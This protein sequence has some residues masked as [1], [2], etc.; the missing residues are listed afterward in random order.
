MDNN[1]PEDLKFDQ[2][3]SYSAVL[4]ALAEKKRDKHLLMGNGFSMAF[5]PKIFSYNA[6]YN[7]IEELNDPVLSKLFGVINTKNFEL[8]MRQLD[9]FIEIAQ[10]LDPDDKGGLVVK[11]RKANELL[12]TSLLDAVSSLHPEHVF[13]VA[14]DQ[15]ERCAQFFNEYLENEGKIFTTNYDLLGTHAQRNGQSNRWFRE[16]F[17]ESRGSSTKKR[18]GSMVKQTDL[19]AIKR[20]SDH[21]LSS[22]LFTLV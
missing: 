3:Q 2:L 20:K 8:V 16:N 7:F 5:D 19:G 13:E 15:S 17:V 18:R 10:A 12:R 22:R 14:Q 9:N 6:L 11:L 21:I 1:I 4:E